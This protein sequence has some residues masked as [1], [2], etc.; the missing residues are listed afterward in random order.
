[1]EQ[2]NNTKNYSEVDDEIDL[3]E[4][5]KVLWE[6]K[7]KLILITSICLILGIV[8]SLVAPKEY[9]SSTSF[10]ITSPN[11]GSNLGAYASVLGMS[12]NSNLESLIENVI[13]SFSIKESIAIKFLPLFETEVQDAI[14]NEKLKN[15]QDHKINFVIKRR[16]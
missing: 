11:Q 1:M 9:K 5:L 15:E 3:L 14:L 2:H 6:S 16:K 8:Y 7:L 4:L 12:E 10:F 13:N